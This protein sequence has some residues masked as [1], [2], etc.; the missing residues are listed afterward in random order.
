MK[1]LFATLAFIALFIGC[2]QEDKNG[3][4]PSTTVGEPI[5]TFLAAANVPTRGTAMSG[6]LDTNAEFRVY[7]TKQERVGNSVAEG[8]TPSIFINGDVVS[9]QTIPAQVVEG[10]KWVWK[11]VTDYYWPQDNYFVNFYAV[12]PAEAPQI[13][14]IL[15]SKQFAF[16]GGNPFP[17]NYD[18]MYA[19]LEHLHRDAI[20]SFI[21]I[22]ESVADNRTVALT[23][24]HL[25]SRI[26]FYGCLSPLFV[27]W[28]WTVEVG[29][30]TIH[31]VNGAGVCDLGA[32]TPVVT[33][34]TPAVPSTYEFVMNPSRRVIDAATVS[35]DSEGNDI[36]LTSPTEIT[37]VI[38][39]EP[40][41]WKPAIETIE[42]TTGCYLAIQMKIKD[43]EGIYQMGSA[44]SYHTVY[45]PF[46]TFVYNMNED[47]ISWQP[48]KTYNYTL[49]FGAGY[50]AAGHPVIQPIKI[51][52]AIQPWTEVSV[53][54]EAQH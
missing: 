34:S 43:A 15:A 16:T 37:A 23:F 33:S 13:S 47:M 11:P 7:A 2:T 46:S 27:N 42:A 36:P 8:S 40:T 54:G 25:L 38:P 5:V 30:I 52:A 29:G 26:M 41:P 50:D 28:G 44:D 14:D 19:K 17:G 51:T 10:Y 12:H 39:Q 1:H 45:V 49:T 3:T 20:S 22:N 6:S 32:A 53:T 35:Q 21:T 24:N 4:A 31:N 48:S 18:L 9:Y